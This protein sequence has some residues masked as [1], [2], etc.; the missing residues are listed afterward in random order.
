MVSGCGLVLA[1]NRRSCSTC[2]RRSRLRI[3]FLVDAGFLP[4]LLGGLLVGLLLS[5]FLLLGLKGLPGM[6]ASKLPG[7]PGWQPVPKPKR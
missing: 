2:S 7:Q 4:G 5:C 3:W 1:L 6:L